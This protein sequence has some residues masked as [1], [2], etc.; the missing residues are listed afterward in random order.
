MRLETITLKNFRQYRDEIIKFAYSD[1]KRNLTVIQGSN[2]AGKTNLLNAITWCLYAQEMHLGDKY[3]ALPLMNT[4]TIADIQSGTV[5]EVLVQ[6]CMRDEEN[7]QII[8][9]RTLSFI[10]SENGR[11][12][13]TSDHYANS[14]DGSVFKIGRQIGKEIKLDPHPEYTLS[15][16]VPATIQEYFFFNGERLD[17][18]FRE[19]SGEKIQ[20]AVFKMSQ[21]DIMKRAI[22]HLKNLKSHLLKRRSDLNPEVDSI[23]A[24]T[25]RCAEQSR[26]H[27][28]QLERQ[29]VERRKAAEQKQEFATKLRGSSVPRIMQLDEERDKVRS[30]L[31]NV[32][33]KLGVLE[34][35]KFAYLVGK[36]PYIL[37]YRAIMVTKKLLESRKEAGDIPPQ[38]RKGFVEKLIRTG[39]CICGT[40]ISEETE[41]RRK[42]VRLLEACDAISNMSGELMEDYGRITGIL[43]SL[44]EFRKTQTNYGKMIRE[45]EVNVAQKSKR[46]DQITDEIEQVDVEKIRF[47]E[48]KRQEYETIEVRL[49][50][51]IGRTKYIVDQDRQKLDDLDRRLMREL[52]KEEKYAVL[53]RTLDLCDETIREAEKTR[54]S[55]ME[56]VRTEIEE[57]TKEQFFSLM[58]KKRT[59]TDVV[60][61]T[62]YNISVKDQSGMEAI[63]TLSAG[64]RQVLALS[65]MAALNIISG[66]NSPIVIDTPLAR[67]SK[68]VKENLADNLSGFFKDK[69]VCLLVTDEEYSSE[70]RKKLLSGI[71]REYKI[72]FMEGTSGSEARVINYE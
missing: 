23:R 5:R 70:V 24:E 14:P 67:L 32:R 36:A 45:S 71:G 38:Y 58:W 62:E 37:G 29:R 12:Q 7:K 42:V 18:Y 66:F 50:E 9:T 8:I 27:E 35:E 4:A 31:A 13:K 2:G 65:F 6:I 17:D 41:H 26:E 39:I 20:K 40:D 57:R 56:D 47:W 68:S 3:K 28:K 21:I 51:N 16:I 69:Q 61:D 59:Y 25:E 53:R 64:E 44:Q 34:K 46:L 48:G 60:I 43:G 55:I 10:K 49:R 54:D 15:K 22:E 72:Q 1:K 11:M 63:G 33:E 52:E 19:S 30:D